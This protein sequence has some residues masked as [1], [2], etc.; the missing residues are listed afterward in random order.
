M[1][2]H[3]IQDGVRFFD[4]RMGTHGTFKVLVPE[5]PG[6]EAPQGHVRVFWDSQSR[7]W[8][9]EEA[10]R[11]VLVVQWDTGAPDTVMAH[12]QNFSFKPW[13]PMFDGHDFV[14]NDWVGALQPEVT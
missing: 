10:L 8:V 13:A 5:V 9:P 6:F 4:P 12:R 1:K 7:S 2:N 11:G 3:E 14:F